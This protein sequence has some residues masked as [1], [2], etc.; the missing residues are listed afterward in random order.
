[1]N[2]KYI[3]FGY[4]NYMK[5]ANNSILNNENTIYYMPN[6]FR[7]IRCIVYHLF[8]WA[9]KYR[10]TSFIPYVLY[11][12]LF[13]LRDLKKTDCIFFIFYEQS[14]GAIEKG[15]LRRLRKTF[16]NSRFVFIF[17]NT[18]A[19]G[20]NKKQ[21]DF[22]KNNRTIYDL[23]TT[24]NETD[25]KDNNFFYYDQVYSDIYAHDYKE[26][27]SDVCFCGLDKGRKKLIETIQNRLE[28]YGI[29]C[30]F[31]IGTPEHKIPHEFI[32]AKTAMTDCILEVLVDT[33][34]PGSS[35]RVAE[36]IANKK[37]LLTN[38]PFIK[39]K[40]YFNTRQFSYFSSPE[41]IDIEF[42]KRKLDDSQFVDPE[43]V[44]PERFLNF[45][46]DT[47]S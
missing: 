40:P 1:M 4:A 32:I 47:L 20:V 45:L 42:I 31:N 11:E 38:N 12:Y 37:K 44:S 15:I 36:A 8:I 34:Q 9:V 27:R 22:I 14:I 5:V 3:F 41:D 24:F 7:G 6:E 35:L 29:N 23:V 26:I 43:I 16:L 19:S 25:A 46:R 13:C 39:N 21:L 2:I 17:T 18:L 30:D 33:S 28:T 10:L